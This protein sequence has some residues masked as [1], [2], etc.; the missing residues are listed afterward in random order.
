MGIK[1]NTPALAQGWLAYMRITVVMFFMSNTQV[2]G[3]YM[4]DIL[5]LRDPALDVPIIMGGTILGMQ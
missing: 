2:A 4:A 3:A 5:S 1:I